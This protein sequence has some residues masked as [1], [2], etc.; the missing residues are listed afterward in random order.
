MSTQICRGF[1]DKQW[2]T[3]KTRLM[4]DGDVQNDEAAWGC[5][6]KVFERRIAERFLRSIE[7]LERAGSKA[8]V[9]VPSDAPSD[10]SRF[11]WT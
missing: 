7:A 9:E 2:P 5:A 1:T 3:L 6:I 10:C 8:D 4:K 11:L